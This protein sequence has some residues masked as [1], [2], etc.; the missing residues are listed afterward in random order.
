MNI[1]VLSCEET[2]ISQGHITHAFSLIIYPL[3]GVGLPKDELWN[4]DKS[5]L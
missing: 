5:S 4:D 2:D 3:D 1:K